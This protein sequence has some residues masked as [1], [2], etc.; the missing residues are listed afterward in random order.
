[1]KV[2]VSGHRQRQLL[3]PPQVWVSCPRPRTSEAGPLPKVTPESVF[4]QFSIRLLFLLSTKRL[5]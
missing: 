5:G 1:M 3:C 4:Y 2:L